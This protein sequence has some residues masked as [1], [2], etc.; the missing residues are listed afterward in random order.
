MSDYE[1][2]ADQ[3][4]AHAEGSA[5]NAHYDRPAV[6]ALLGPVTGLRVLD[7]GCGPGLYLEELLR[8]GAAKVIGSDASQR[9]VELARARVGENAELRVHDLNEPMPWMST[10]SGERVVMALTIHHLERPRVALHEAHRVLTADGRIVISTVH[11]ISDWMQLGGSYF[12]DEIV[13]D[14][15]NVGWDVRFRRAPLEALVADFKAA[16]FVIEDLVEPRP[17]PSMAAAF[18][19]VAERLEREPAF[20][21]FRLR[22]A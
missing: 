18:P 14:T 17:A 12:A 3:F 9:M 6:L 8:R 10:G 15:W 22:K 19:D 2:F 5:F 4:A 13:E 20:I 11:P 1:A 7:V 21:A 16:G